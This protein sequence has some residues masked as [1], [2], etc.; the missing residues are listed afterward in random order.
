MEVS[1]ATD[2][3]MCDRGAVRG[4]LAAL[5]IQTILENGMDLPRLSSDPCA[6]LCSLPFEG[7][8]AFVA[9]C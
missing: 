9:Q 6:H 5:T 8:G 2:I 7:Q 3:G 1:R 4:G